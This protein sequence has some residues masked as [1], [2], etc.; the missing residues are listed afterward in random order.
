MPPLPVSPPD[1][2]PSVSLSRTASAP[3]VYLKN[4][5]FGRPK[6]ALDA[7][8]DGR[9]ELTLKSL[10]SRFRRRRLPSSSCHELK[11]TKPHELETRTTRQYFSLDVPSSTK[12]CSSIPPQ[13]LDSHGSRPWIMHQSTRNL[14]QIEEAGACAP[15]TEPADCPDSPLAA[16]EGEFVWCSTFDGET[17]TMPPAPLPLALVRYVRTI[18]CPLANLTNDLCRDEPA[19][20][21]SPLS[22]LGDE[23]GASASISPFSRHARSSSDIWPL[24]SPVASSPSSLSRQRPSLHLERMLPRSLAK[25]FPSQFD[26]HSS[27]EGSYAYQLP[28]PHRPG[29]KREWWEVK[30]D[31][32]RS[33]VLPQ[34]DLVQGGQNSLLDVPEGSPCGLVTSGPAL[35]PNRRWRRYTGEFSHSP[36]PPE[37]PRRLS[38][39]SKLDASKYGTSRLDTCDYASGKLNNA[40]KVDTGFW[41]VA[42]PHRLMCQS[43]DAVVGQAS[44]HPL[45][46][47]V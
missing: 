10:L 25:L 37:I 5:L 12:E 34:V 18:S 32:L 31:M 26:D 20:C 6:D 29:T 39:S 22:S 14:V 15:A 1:H 44:M 27:L 41:P 40:S 38:V 7:Y 16:P 21:A 2:D 35:S 33:A 43:S 13:N 30:N 8:L 24:S 4:K 3:W 9:P 17:S 28:S 19:K 42:G 46:V 11:S 23:R 47:S 45:A 36:A